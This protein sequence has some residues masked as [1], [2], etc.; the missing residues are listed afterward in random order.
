MG[1]VPERSFTR[2]L[3]LASKTTPEDSVRYASPGLA[4]EVNR[5]PVGRHL[6]KVNQRR[7]LADTRGDLT[8]ELVLVEI[9][10]DRAAQ[11][12]NRVRY[13]PLER[14]VEQAAI[15]ARECKVDGEQRRRRKGLT[16]RRAAAPSFRCLTESSL[17]TAR[18]SEYTGGLSKGK[19]CKQICYLIV[20]N[21]KIV[22]ISQVGDVI[23]KNPLP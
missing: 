17:G 13:R 3:G 6:P 7:H 4:R 8:G 19:I 15:V 2:R 20:V 21:V 18:Q 10:G 1:M 22:Q 12:S 5:Q 9:K 14:V 11:L 16:L 23:G